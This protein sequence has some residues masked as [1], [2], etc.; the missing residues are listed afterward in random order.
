MA[1]HH[2][3][4]VALAQPEVSDVATLGGALPAPAPH[5]TTTSPGN[6]KQFLGRIVNAYPSPVTRFYCHAR[7]TIININMLHILGLCLRGQRRILDIGCGFGLFGCYFS[8]L[9]PEITYHGIDLS[10]K[11]IGEAQQVAARL[12]LTNASFACAD[13]NDLA[14]T[15]QY[16]AIMM[17]DLMHHIDDEAKRR[18][19]ATCAQHLEPGGR[20]I[21]KDI[22]T[23]PWP[24]LAFTWLLDVL[25][26]RSNDMWYWDEAQFHT[27]LSGYCRRV[28]TLPITDWLPYPHIVYLAEKW[29]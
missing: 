7:F 24:K 28:D 3:F 15:E 19:M 9:Y 2:Y 1:E 11:R 23:H 25:M 10:A 12:G 14:L 26:T 21:I 4:G 22:T 8:A 20:L 16:D 29:G 13:A 17:L 5:W 18:L 6:Y 27:L